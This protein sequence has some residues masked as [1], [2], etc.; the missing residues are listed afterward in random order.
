MDGRRMRRVSTSGTRWLLWLLVSAGLSS[1]CAGKQDPY[2]V[3]HE[4][5]DDLTAEGAVVLDV[6]TREHQ[7]VGTVP[8][9]VQVPL[10]ELSYRVGY[11]RV[12]TKIVVVAEDESRSKKAAKL[13]R[14]A[15]FTVYEV[16]EFD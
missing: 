14:D 4:R 12:D 9:A 6:R 15:G 8:G 10:E 2:V 5:V 13:L 11:L 7:K 3:P 16:R 1:A